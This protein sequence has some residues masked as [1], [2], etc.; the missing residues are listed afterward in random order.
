MTDAEPFDLLLLGAGHAHLHVLEKLSALP[1]D[2]R[3]RWSVA[4]VTPHSVALYPNM[5]PGFVAG[6]YDADACTIGLHRL[7]EQSG[8]QLL[9]ARAM[10]VDASARTVK[11]YGTQSGQ[12]DVR[13]RLLS[14]NTGGVIDR[15]QL[16][17]RIPGVTEHG[18]FLRPIESFFPL[19]QRIEAQIGDAERQLAVIGGG[20]AGVEM[21]LAMRQRWPQCGVHLLTGGDPPLSDRPRRV[22]RK[23]QAVLERC[24]V[25]VHPMACT[26]LSATHFTLSDDTTHLCDVALIAVGSQAPRWLARSGLTLDGRGFLAVNVYQQSLSHPEVFAAGDIASRVDGAYPRSGTYAALAGG[27]LASNLVSALKGHAMTPYTPPP[28]TAGWLSCGDQ[29]ALVTW[30]PWHWEG[31]WAWRQKDKLDRAFVA[32]FR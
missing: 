6:H 3:S 15:V 23:A 31:P 19:W 11:V 22:Q 28:R 2:E 10:D 14:V 7:I 17:N 13:Y 1:R 24:R 5:L 32:R 25:V 27:P 29:R 8:V 9:S 21:A 30:G 4:L 18:H 12:A 16:E 20:A 26:G